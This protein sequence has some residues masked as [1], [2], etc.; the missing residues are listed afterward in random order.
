MGKYVEIISIVFSPC[1]FPNK[2]H[3]KVYIYALPEKRLSFFFFFSVSSL[4]SPDSSV[5]KESSCDA[6]DPGSVPGLGRCPGEGIGYPL[7]YSCPE[8]QTEEPGSLQSMGSQRVGHDWATSLSF[9]PLTLLPLHPKYF[10]KADKNP[11]PILQSCQLWLLP[12]DFVFFSATSFLSSTVT[13]TVNS[14]AF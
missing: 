11:L 14:V 1:L 7:Q 8:N 13:W 10:K 4:M 12:I 3:L 9:F 2:K 6:G 5:G